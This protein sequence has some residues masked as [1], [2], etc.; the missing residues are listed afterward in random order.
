MLRIVL[1]FFL[2][3][4][5]FKPFGFIISFVGMFKAKFFSRIKSIFNKNLIIL[6]LVLL[7]GLIVQRTTFN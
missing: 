3:K 1:L 7:P 5:I 4:F 6:L 2:I